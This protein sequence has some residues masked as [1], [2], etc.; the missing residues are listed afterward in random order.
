[1][2]VVHRNREGDDLPYLAPVHVGEAGVQDL[3]VLL[4]PF[5]RIEGTVRTPRED[6]KWSGMLRVT[7]GRMG[8]ETEVRVGPEGR[9]VLN[10][11]PPGEWYL[12]IDANLA[13]RADDVAFRMYVNP[14]P[15]KTLR[16]T[17]SGNLPLELLLTGEAGKITGTADEAGLVTVTEASGLFSSGKVAEIAQDGSFHLDVAPGEYRVGLGAAALCSQLVTVQGGESVSVHLKA[18]T[19]SGQ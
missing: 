18:C 5:A 10:A 15:P 7:L 9:F 14:A 17:E 12:A 19:A 1:M 6:L 3:E 11:I 4:P 16:V 2:A 8:Y 13:H